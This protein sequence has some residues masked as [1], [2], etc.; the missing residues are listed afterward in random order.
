[1]NVLDHTPMKPTLRA[2]QSV[3]RVVVLE[4]LSTKAGNSSVR[5]IIFHLILLFHSISLIEVYDVG[6]HVIGIASH[7]LRGRGSSREVDPLTDRDGTGS[8]EERPIGEGNG[9]AVMVRFTEV[10]D[11]VWPL[12]LVFLLPSCYNT[13]MRHKTLSCWSNMISRCHN[14]KGSGYKRYGARGIVVCDRWRESSSNFIQDMGYAPSRKHSIERIDNSKGYCKENCKWA[15]KDEQCRNTR[16]NVYLTL[17]GI[18]MV[19]KDWANKLG[20]AE[21]SLKG[22][23]KRGWSIRKTLTTPQRSAK[24]RQRNTSRN[25]L[26]TYKGQTKTLIEWAE[27]LGIKKTALRYRIEN[28]NVHEAF[29]TPILRKRR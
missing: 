9:R 14:P 28:W 6:L 7:C 26:I 4:A 29:T 21:A 13:N 24:E 27:I 5:K 12:T 23:L 3:G 18:T 17:D 20:I 10:E 11:H 2:L 15:T 22:R 8:T 19:R 25:H 1:M 16:K